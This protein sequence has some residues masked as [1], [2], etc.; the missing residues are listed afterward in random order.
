M[1]W[2]KMFVMMGMIAAFM[3]LVST[4]ALAQSASGSHTQSVGDSTIGASCSQVS[5]ISNANG[6]KT[7]NFSLQGDVRI[8]GRTVRTFDVNSSARQANQSPPAKSMTIT[9]NGNTISVSTTPFSR[10]FSI[11]SVRLQIF[12]GPVPVFVSAGVGASIGASISASDSSGTFGAGFS[13]SGGLSTSITAAVGTPVAYIGVRGSASPL[14]TTLSPRLTFT[15]A[16]ISATVDLTIG[17]SASVAL[18]VRIA[19][20]EYRHV[21]ASWSHPYRTWRILARTL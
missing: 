7:A 4:A 19:W 11:V 1:A 13:F 8:L 20:F 10:S 21:L 17:A 3:A 15:S 16:T 9:V 2:R 14:T 5:T 12:V 18:V 6:V